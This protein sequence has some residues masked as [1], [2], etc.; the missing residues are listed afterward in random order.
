MRFIGKKYDA[1]K[2]IMPIFIVMVLIL[3]TEI[4][5]EYIHTDKSKTMVAASEQLIKLEV[6]N[7]QKERLKYLTAYI[8]NEILSDIEANLT[9]TQV[10]R[11]YKTVIQ[12]IFNIFLPLITYGVFAYCLG[13][14]ILRRKHQISIM[15]TYIG[16][17]APPNITEYAF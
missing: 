10:F 6:L 15:A 5:Q 13:Y 4:P 9:L 8:R 17:H 16:G 2:S 11:D 7:F 12:K 1:Y 3:Q 14:F